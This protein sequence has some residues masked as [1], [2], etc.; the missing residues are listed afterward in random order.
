MTIR[1]IGQLVSL[2]CAKALRVP[3]ERSETRQLCCSGLIYG[4]VT[5]NSICGDQELASDRDEGEFC[6]LSGSSQLPVEGFEA[7][8]AS[9]CGKGG[10]VEG[11]ADP[12]AAAF[13]A[14]AATKLSTVDIEGRKPCHCGGGFGREAAE[15]GHQGYEGDRGDWPDAW[16]RTKPPTNLL[17]LFGLP[18]DLVDLAVPRGDPCIQPIQVGVDIGCDLRIDTFAPARA[19]LLA[20]MNELISALMS[21][22]KLLANRVHSS[23]RLWRQALRH[24]GEHPGIDRIRFGKKAGRAREVTRPSWVHPREPDAVIRQGASQLPVVVTGRLEH[25]QN[26]LIPPAIDQAGD[27]KQRIGDALIR[28][29]TALKHVKVSFGDID[30]NEAR[31]YDHGAYPCAA[32]SVAAA[33]INCAG[34]GFVVRARIRPARGLA[35]RD[36]TISRPQPF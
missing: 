23:L 21:E 6:G 30:S 31:V 10:H 5:Q 2:Y 34:L 32:R 4:V 20:S 1:L 15:L 35:T 13:D 7:W 18:K 12:F 3:G 29:A 16:N 9:G 8:T 24:G 26:V 28:P 27:D 17:E 25:H 14:P 22:R 11:V 19:L 33:S 36:P